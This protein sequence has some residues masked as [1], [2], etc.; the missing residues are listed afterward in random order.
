MLH[1]KGKFTWDNGVVYE[2][3]FTY[4][5]IQGHGVYRWTDGSI[6]TG[7]VVNGLR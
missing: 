6:Y 7:Q 3:E 1:G 5:K 4:N 2:G